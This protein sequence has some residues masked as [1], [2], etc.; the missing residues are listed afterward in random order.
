MTRRSVRLLFVGFLLSVGPLWAWDYEGHRMVNQVALASL[1]TNFPAFVLTPEARE[2]VAFLSCEPDR[3]RNTKEVPLSNGT[4]PDHYL[5]L[6]DLPDYGLS[7]TNLSPARYEFAAQLAVARAL[8]PEK[9]PPIDPAKNDDKTRTLIGFLPWAIAEN[10]GKLKAGFSYLK[11]LEEH[12]TPE[13]IA[14]AQQNILYVMGTMG[15]FAGDAGQ[16]LHTTRHHHGWIGSNPNHY[17]T[18]FSIHSWVDGGYIKKIGL[19]FE[20]L[21]PSVRSAQLIPG[22]ENAPL[23]TGL[24]PQALKFVVDQHDLVEPLYVLNQKGDLSDFGQADSKGRKFIVGQLLKSGQF[25]GDLW[26]SAWK[27]ATVDTYLRG[28]LID[29][30][31]NSGPRP[32]ATERK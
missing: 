21:K 11:A 8:H 1:P 12:G 32:A 13:E 17:A 20:Q 4:N 25:L 23:E 2:R 30:K 16:P 6:D 31:S 24:F 26:L 28:K 18:N 29:R 7:P 5:D 14:N 15:H 9:F 19:N 22:A 27:T 3:W 10:Y